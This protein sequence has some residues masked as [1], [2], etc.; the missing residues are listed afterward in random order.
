MTFGHAGDLGDIIYALPTIRALGG[1]TL[2]LHAVKWTREPMTETKVQSLRSL[3][4][5][6][7]YIEDVRW[8]G[9]GEKVAVNL[10]DFRQS[11]MNEGGFRKFP[12]RNICEWILLTH[13]LSP[14]EQAKRWLVGIEPIQRARVVVNRTP[15]YQNPSFP[16]RRVL[17]HYR[18]EM[19]FVGSAKEHATFCSDFKMAKTEIPHQQTGS[20]LA[21]AQVIAGADLFVGN[22]SCAYAIAEG[23]KKPAILEVCRWMPNC[24]FE[25]ED[26]A[27]GWGQDVNL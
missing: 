22:Q 17:D 15:R 23:M 2:C 6:Q 1:G 24:L 27:H 21:L 13:C 26:C 20:L 19:V 14:D 3:L 9:D 11:Y 10:N 12:R 8:L 16:W 18:G 25:R 4:I 7:P 5:T